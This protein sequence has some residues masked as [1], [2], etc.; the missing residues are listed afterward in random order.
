[1]EIVSY[2]DLPE[3]AAEIRRKVFVEEQG[4]NSEFDDVDSYAKHLVALEDRS[5]VGTCRLFPRKGTSSYIIGRIAVLK[6]YRGRHV[7]AKLLSAA[8]RLAADL[9]GDRVLLHAQLQA[10]GFYE[11]QGYSACGEIDLEE[12]CPHIWMAKNI[13]EL[14]ADPVQ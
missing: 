14:S 8:E 5:P 12:N 9:G 2:N 4:F 3:D 10:K 7:G 6:Q 13:D 1:M 11:K